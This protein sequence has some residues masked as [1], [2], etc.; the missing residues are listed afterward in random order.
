MTKT[1]NDGSGTSR[2]RFL[3]AAGAVTLGLAGSQLGNVAWAKGDLVAFV[4]TQ[5]AG[6]SG[7]V[8]SMIGALKKLAAEKGFEMRAIYAQDAA[9]YEQIFRS[10]ADAGAAVIVSTFNEVAE[11]FKALAPS[12]PKTKWIQL[13]GDPFEPAMPNVVTVSYDYYLGCYLSGMF[14]SKISSTGKIG[15]IGG[16]S[17]P[18][19][20]ADLNAMKAAVAATNPKG[21]VTGA[22]AGSFQD[23]AKG[24]EIATQMFQSGV[25][26]IQTDSAA[27]D[28][29]IIQA[30]NE[31]QNRMVSAISPEQY[32]I[33]PSTV[34]ALVALDFG[35]SLYNEVSRAM[36][37]DWKGGGH[38]STGIG[39]GVID[40]VLSPVFVEKGPPE[41][42]KKAQAIWPEIAKARADIMSGALKVPFKT[43]L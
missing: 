7:P 37:P 41:L 1:S 14:A 22:F 40:F 23:P 10:L 32:K 34:I 28:T 19:L 8:D 11:P 26:Y 24:H 5:A 13:Y 31:G 12:Y 18:G 15:Y 43:E 9:T 39:T 36:S 4:H 29:G 25:D 42:V 20:N 30:A 27:T 16:I 21:S 2:R 3:Q 6:D 38:V 33:G 35:Q 17:I